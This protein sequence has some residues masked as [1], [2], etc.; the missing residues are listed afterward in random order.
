MKIRIS[1]KCSDLFYMQD[2]DSGRDYQGYVPHFLG[3]YGDYIELDIDTETGKI[4][5]WD[6]P[7]E[8]QINEYFDGED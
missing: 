5:N 3:S 7:T 8:E 2:L 6:V 4:I 1:G